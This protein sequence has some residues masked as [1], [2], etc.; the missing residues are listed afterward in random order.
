MLAVGRVERN[1][2]CRTRE[3]NMIEGLDC[4]FLQKEFVLYEFMLG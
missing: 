3:P 1:A 2:A 4:V